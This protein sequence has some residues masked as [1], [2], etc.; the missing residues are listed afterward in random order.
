MTT[1]RDD[2]NKV[3]ESVR[4]AL[5]TR[6]SGA[7]YPESIQRQ[8]ALYAAQ[9]KLEGIGV[10]RAAVELGVSY[11]VLRAWIRSARGPRG[12]AKSIATKRARETRKATAPRKSR[13]RFVP[14]AI[15]KEKHSTAEESR[16]MVH[17][18]CGI[19]V[20]GLSLDALAT[21]IRKLS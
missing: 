21:L 5:A 14:V 19:R 18:P 1:N 17:G 13:E 4:E 20:E 3:R 9:R 16:W 10:G 11:W 12:D 8:G 2:L 6:V 7:R 15:A